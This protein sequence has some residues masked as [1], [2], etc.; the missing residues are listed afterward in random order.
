MTAAAAF[1]F[2]FANLYCFYFTQKIGKQFSNRLFLN[3]I[4]LAALVV[5]LAALV[6]AVVVTLAVL[7]V[8]AD[9]EAVV[10]HGGVVPDRVVQGVRTG[11]T[12]W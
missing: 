4:G 2:G 5:R 11:R 3:F 12:R 9:G 7:L 6:V 8:R 1:T 10:V